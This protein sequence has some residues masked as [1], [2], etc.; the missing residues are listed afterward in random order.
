MINSPLGVKLPPRE[1]NN[2]HILSLFTFLQ[3]KLKRRIRYIE[4]SL[5]VK[6]PGMLIIIKKC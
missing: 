1:Y 3:E 4:N 2:I 5:W 6:I